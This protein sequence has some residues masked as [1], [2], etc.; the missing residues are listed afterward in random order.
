MDNLCDRMDVR[1]VYGDSNTI[2]NHA[3]F[4]NNTERKRFDQLL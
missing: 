1:V 2:M 3:V 4:F